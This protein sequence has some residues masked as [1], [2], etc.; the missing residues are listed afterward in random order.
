[1]KLPSWTHLA[2]EKVISSGCWWLIIMIND[3][4]D[5]GWCG[6]TLSGYLSIHPSSFFLLPPP[7]T[8]NWFHLAPINLRTTM[9]VYLT[10]HHVFILHPNTLNEWMNGHWERTLN[11]KH[12]YLTMG[13]VRSISIWILQLI[14]KHH[15]WHPL[16]S[17]D[18]WW[19]SWFSCRLQWW[20]CPFVDLFTF[21]LS[22]LLD[23]GFISPTTTT[24]WSS[25][26]SWWR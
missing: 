4:W 26:S 18:N 14:V 24:T 6:L 3:H 11:R 9:G 23:Y 21:S 16:M 1:M 17:V 20:V 2:A 12:L 5:G 25:S 15:L 22:L 10:H 7:P 19:V 8:I 13:C